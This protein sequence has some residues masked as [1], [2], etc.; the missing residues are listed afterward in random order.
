MANGEVCQ[1]YYRTGGKYHKPGLRNKRKAHWA[2]IR[3][4]ERR[5]TER[6]AKAAER[7]EREWD[8]QFDNPY[9]D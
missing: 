6:K 5:E 1:P 8:Q 3:D 9:G 7:S 2:R 4:T